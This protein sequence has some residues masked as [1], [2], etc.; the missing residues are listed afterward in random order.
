M[1]LDVPVHVFYATADDKSEK[2]KFRKPKPGLWQLMVDTVLR[3]KSPSECLLC[4]CLAPFPALMP[5]TV[6]SCD[7]SLSAT[8][9]VRSRMLVHAQGCPTVSLSEMLLAETATSQTLTSAHALLPP[10]SLAPGL[11]HVPLI[12]SSVLPLL[13]RHCPAPSAALSC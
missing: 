11:E 13:G 7:A 5:S 10:H 9:V 12:S 6:R 4:P 2:D 8:S 3:S 1:Q